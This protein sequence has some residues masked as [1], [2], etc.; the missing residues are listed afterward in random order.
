VFTGILLLSI[1]NAVPTFEN[2]FPS[3]IPILF[4]NTVSRGVSIRVSIPN[5]FLK[6]IFS[7]LVEQYYTA[8]RRRAHLCNNNTVYLL[9]CTCE[10]AVASTKTALNAYLIVVSVWDGDGTSRLFFF[11]TR[12]YK[13]LLNIIPYITIIMCTYTRNN[14]DAYY[15]YAYGYCTRR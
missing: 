13:M 8:D 5:T 6:S 3:S 11:R 4:L 12:V 15:A 14:N 9:R 10:I 2:R 7:R 1:P